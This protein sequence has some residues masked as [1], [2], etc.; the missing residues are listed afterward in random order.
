MGDHADDA[1]NE[2]LDPYW[3]D[4]EH[5]PIGARKRPGAPRP[6]RLTQQQALNQVRKGGPPEP[7]QPAL[8]ECNTYEELRTALEGL[9]PTWYPDLL[10]AMTIAAYKKKVFVPNGAST[11]IKGI[12]DKL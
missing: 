6:Q 11:F 3:G 5:A 4:G 1:L 9:P 12:E 10:R 8:L 2:A 7:G